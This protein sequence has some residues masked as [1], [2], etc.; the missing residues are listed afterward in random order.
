[1]KFDDNSEMQFGKYRGK[2]MM[3]V[4]ASYL[5]WLC[6]QGDC[7]KRNPDLAEYIEDNRDTLEKEAE[8]R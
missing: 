5:L 6:D 2:K 8:G 1:M 3:D 4:P 7:A